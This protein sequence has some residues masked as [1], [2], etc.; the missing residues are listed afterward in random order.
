MYVLVEPAAADQEV[1]DVDGRRR[2]RRVGDQHEQVE[3]R[4][5]RALGEEPV[6]GRRGDAR[7]LVPGANGW[8]GRFRYIA[9]SATI[10]AVAVITAD[11]SV[12]ASSR[13]G[14]STAIVVRLCGGSV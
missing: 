1:L 6:E 2:S 7:A 5:G 12:L 8:P 13:S 4:A 14:E 11:T 10:G 3:E 9:R